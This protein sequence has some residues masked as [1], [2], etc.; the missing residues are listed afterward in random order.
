[1]YIR[2]GLRSIQQFLFF[3]FNYWLYFVHYYVVKILRSYIKGKNDDKAQ[4][5]SRISYG[6]S[7]PQ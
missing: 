7:Y 1:M 5:I 4:M 6:Y 2:Y 3:F